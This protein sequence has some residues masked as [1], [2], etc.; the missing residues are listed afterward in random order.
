MLAGCIIRVQK[1]LAETT[2]NV[3]SKE[4]SNITFSIVLQQP[5]IIRLEYFLVWYKLCCSEIS[6]FLW[7]MPCVIKNLLTSNL[8]LWPGYLTLLDMVAVITIFYP[9]NDEKLYN[10]I[11]ILNLFSCKVNVWCLMTKFVM[12]F[13]VHKRYTVWLQWSNLLIERF[14]K[15]TTFWCLFSRNIVDV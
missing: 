14:K 15:N 9:L 11:L 2:T 5:H 1:L 12:L 7:V 13:S 8:Y 10:I 4:K 6:I 3:S